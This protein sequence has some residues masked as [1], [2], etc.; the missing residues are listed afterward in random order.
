VKPAV[1]QLH[2]RRYAFEGRFT[3]LFSSLGVSQPAGQDSDR[4]AQLAGNDPV[5]RP[6]GAARQ[7]VPGD[8][9]LELGA[10]APRLAFLGFD[11]AFSQMR[12]LGRARRHIWHCQVQTAEIA[13]PKPANSGENE[14][15][16]R[17]A[18]SW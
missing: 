2:S 3:G 4:E 15:P 13:T 8:V 16:R 10:I 14:W 1:V 11:D 12:A 5:A 9:L 17:N 7:A 18:E 6:L